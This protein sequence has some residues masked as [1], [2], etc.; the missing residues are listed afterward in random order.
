MYARRVHWLRPSDKT[1]AKLVSM[2]ETVTSPKEYRSRHEVRLMAMPP[3]WRGATRTM[4]GPSGPSGAT[5]GQDRSFRTASR[6]VAPGD[7]GGGISFQG[8][9]RHPDQIPRPPFDRIARIGRPAGAIPRTSLSKVDMQ[10]PRSRRGGG[11]APVTHAS[12]ECQGR[13]AS[14]RR[15]RVKVVPYRLP[16]RLKLHD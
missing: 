7:A 16:I 2:H 5:S 11:T 9:N 1:G 3:S 10:P 13:G 6:G 15:S 12:V 8:L 14:A 4:G